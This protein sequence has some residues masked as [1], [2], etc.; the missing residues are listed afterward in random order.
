MPTF[1]DTTGF[2]Q[3]V[4][5]LNDESSTPIF[6]FNTD[7]CTKLFRELA[8]ESINKPAIPRLDP[9]YLTVLSQALLFVSLIILL[10]QLFA[11]P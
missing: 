5:V 10:Q 7:F 9:T 2:R 6:I 4:A 1:I 8:L 11:L 3:K